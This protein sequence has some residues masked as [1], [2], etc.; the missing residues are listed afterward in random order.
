MENCGAMVEL[1][2]AAGDNPH[3]MDNAGNNP[4]HFAAKFGNP[5]TVRALL[6]AGA[7]VDRC[8]D[9]LDTPLALAAGE[10]G[11]VEVVRELLAAGAQIEGR[12]LEDHFLLTPLLRHGGA[13]V[14]CG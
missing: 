7:D 3:N 4:L 9:E 2:C 12:E 13:A 6:A 8:D 14:C 10:S 5:D 1:L 11:S